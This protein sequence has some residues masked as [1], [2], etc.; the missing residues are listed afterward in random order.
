MSRKIVGRTVGTPLSPKKVE[1][2]LKP[3]KSVNGAK[4]DANG[5]VTVDGVAG[6]STGI[7][8]YN[9][10]TDTIEAEFLYVEFD[11]EPD[12]EALEFFPEPKKGDMVISAS[13][14]LFVVAMISEKGIRM[15]CVKDLNGAP[16]EGGATV[17]EV[18]EALPDAGSAS[19]VKSGNVITAEVVM[20]D[21]SISTSVIELENGLPKKVTTDGVECP[22]TFE[23]FETEDSGG[24]SDLPV[25][26]LETVLDMANQTQIT[27]TDAEKLTAAAANG[28]FT[29]IRA[30]ML[31]SGSE[32]QFTS[33]FTYWNLPGQGEIFITVLQGVTLRLMHPTGASYWV[34]MVEQ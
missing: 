32:N 28:T 13:G 7:V 1:S 2:E 23:G 21:G 30:N 8:Y 3:V 14:Q 11:G 18:L 17:E 22:M 27:G 12:W 31:I 19:F 4:P 6:A 9:V 16:G 24:G 10:H 20:D 5:N 26:E 34:S 29:V 15:M 33:G 25:V